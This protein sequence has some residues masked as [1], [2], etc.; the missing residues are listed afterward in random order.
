MTINYV[1]LIP[2][3]NHTPATDVSNMQAN[4]DANANIWNTDHVGFNTGG[5]TVPSGAHNKITFPSSQGSPGPSGTQTIIYPS[6]VNGYLEP[7]IAS[8]K[9]GANQ[10]LG[11]SPFVKCMV[12]FVGINSF[13]AAITPTAGYLTFNVASIS[14]DTLTQITLTFTQQLPSANYYLFNTGQSTYTGATVTVTK[15]QSNIIFKTGAGTFVNSIFE[16]MVI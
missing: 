2:N 13:P 16:F 3:P 11:Y 15:N 6:D 5:P 7:F 9:A 10:I 14:Q 4:N 8:C 1:P 12:R